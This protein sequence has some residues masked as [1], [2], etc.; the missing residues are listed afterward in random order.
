M[1]GDRIPDATRRMQTLL[2]LFEA[3]EEI[4]RQNLRRR[5]PWES[6][7]SLQRRFLAWRW[8]LPGHGGPEAPVLPLAL[9]P[10]R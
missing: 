9:A 7:E 3:G 4:M 2:E 10:T 1:D 5:F 8:R 6:E